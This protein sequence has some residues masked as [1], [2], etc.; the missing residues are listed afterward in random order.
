MRCSGYRLAAC[1]LSRLTL[2][3]CLDKFTTA[4]RWL[5]LAF[6]LANLCFVS[7]AGSVVVLFCPGC[8]VWAVPREIREPLSIHSGTSALPDMQKGSLSAF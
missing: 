4:N 8:R 2:I 6:F 1:L 7:E 5:L 3:F